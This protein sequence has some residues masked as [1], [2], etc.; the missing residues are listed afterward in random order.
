M[1]NKHS[2]HDE[3]HQN[4]I[5]YFYLLGHTSHC[6]KLPVTVKLNAGD[7]A[8]I[9]ARVSICQ[10]CQLSECPELSE[11]VQA[12]T[13]PLQ[14]FLPIRRL[15]RNVLILVRLVLACPNLQLKEV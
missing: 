1:W 2:I 6:K 9:A 5:A 4:L 11:L 8:A 7:D 13:E 12:I 14:T 3:L 15:Y 10:G